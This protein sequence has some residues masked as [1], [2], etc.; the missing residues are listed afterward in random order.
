M[1][2]TLFSLMLLIVSTSYAQKQNGIA[3]AYGSAKATLS[4]E[5]YPSISDSQSSISLS[6][7]SDVNLSQMFDIQPVFSIGFG[8]KIDDERNYGIAY[9]TN[10]QFYPSRETLGLFLGP[11]VGV[12]LVL[13]DIDTES[14][15]QAGVG[16]G[17]QIGY[18][19]S[20][21]TT[22]F[23]EYARNLTNQS[24]IKNVKIKSNAFGLGLQYEVY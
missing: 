20:D 12:S 19:F 10:I 11:T 18:D 24:K 1:K 7:F 22:L 16:G 4:G 21:R 6:L 15:K 3:M 13:S 8:E 14:I 9:S 17:F 23:V 5:G 2:K